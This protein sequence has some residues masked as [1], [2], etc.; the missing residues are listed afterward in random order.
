MVELRSKIVGILGTY[1]VSDE[2]MHDLMREIG[3][4][5]SAECEEALQAGQN[6]G[7]DKGHT[8]G[9]DEGKAKG[10]NEGYGTALDEAETR[11]HTNT[12]LNTDERK[13][14]LS[15]LRG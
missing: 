6:A 1:G 5:V 9:Y 7:Y 2:D 4:Y 11:I 14:A 13:R 3:R 10:Y 15:I 12:R 8:E